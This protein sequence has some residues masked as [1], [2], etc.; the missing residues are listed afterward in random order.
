MNKK[1]LCIIPARAGSKAIKNKN[2]IKINKKPLIQYS[3]DIAIKL[4]KYCDIVVS[5]DSKKIIKILKNNNLKFTGFRPKKLSNDKVKTYDVVNYEIKKKEK[6][7][8]NKYEGILLLQPTCPIRDINK[9][10]K[11]FKILKNKRYDSLVSVTSVNAIHPVRMKKF[12][13]NYLI[14]YLNTK[15]E[16]MKP[17]QDLSKVYIR[18]GSI[19]LIKRNAFFRYKSLVGKRCYG[20]ILE[21]AESINID[22]IDDIILLKH[23]IKK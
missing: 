13:N 3:I 22:T 4:K 14:N 20:M 10:I 23:K 19:Y 16:N 12:R 2:F 1:Y 11:A 5:S 6:E 21:G 17:R 8:K 15:S 18:S 7:I 9:I